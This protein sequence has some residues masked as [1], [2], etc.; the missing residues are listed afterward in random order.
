VTLGAEA[1]PSPELGRG[2]GA[3]EVG[4]L[5]RPAAQADEVMVVPGL[6][7]DVR[8]SRVP[9]EWSHRARAPQHVDRAIDRGEAQLR[10]P[11]PGVLEE[12]DGSEA[13]FA[14]DDQIE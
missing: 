6:A 10:P 8:R 12:V 14:I 5:D 7:A 1:V 13:A 2:G 3:A 9:D 4:L 11:L